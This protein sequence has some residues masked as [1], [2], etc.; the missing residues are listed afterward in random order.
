VR[1][2]GEEEWRE[3]AGVPG[4]LDVV[5]FREKVG[6]WPAGTHGTVVNSLDGNGLIEVVDETG[7]TLDLVV[8]PYLKLNVV[9]SAQQE[10]VH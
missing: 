10:R 6:S 7:R 9:W 8:V 1:H 4:E 5:A 3:E 2:S